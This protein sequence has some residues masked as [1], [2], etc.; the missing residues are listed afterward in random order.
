MSWSRDRILIEQYSLV[1]SAA[2]G[3]EWEKENM[4]Y[5]NAEYDVL[6]NF[7]YRR[8]AVD[9][10]FDQ[11][12]GKGRD[13]YMQV[14]YKVTSIKAYVSD[15]E[16]AGAEVTDPKLLKDLGE[17]AVM[18]AREQAIERGEPEYGSMM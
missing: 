3:F 1:K 6:C 8:E 9:Y 4:P 17:E 2:S 18:H 10:Q 5:G 11:R 12:L 14:P 13:L 15:P 7:E 16:G